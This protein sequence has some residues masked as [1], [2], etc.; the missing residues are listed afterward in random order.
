MAGIRRDS[1]A[2]QAS[3]D[4]TLCHTVAQVS[5]R[6]TN[7][8]S[9]VLL[10]ILTAGHVELSFALVRF[11]PVTPPAIGVERSEPH[12]VSEE[13]IC[14]S[15]PQPVRPNISQLHQ[16]PLD[17]FVPNELFQRPPPAI[18]ISPE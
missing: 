8:L 18:V 17:L 5:L 2:K 4:S 6:P 11:S 13:C 1:I 10:L 14:A 12:Q 9:M 16:S 7:R 15:S 3:A